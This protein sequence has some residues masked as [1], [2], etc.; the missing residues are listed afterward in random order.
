M[1]IGNLINALTGSF[2][3][4]WALTENFIDIL[5]ILLL[6]YNHFTGVE[7]PACRPRRLHVVC[8]LRCVDFSREYLG[9]NMCKLPQ[10]PT[11]H[12]ME[13]K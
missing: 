7:V 10:V 3:V 11:R 5:C 4:Y 2:V 6:L 1:L 8:R 13:T 12:I 9:L